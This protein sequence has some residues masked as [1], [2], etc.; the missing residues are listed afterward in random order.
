MYQ[1]RSR[2]PAYRSSLPRQATGGQKQLP[3]RGALVV[4]ICLAVLGVLL[5]L[6]TIVVH[7]G[8][9]QGAKTTSS[10][11]AGRSPQATAGAPAGFNKQ[12]YSVDQATS[13]WVVVNKKRALNPLTY[14]PANLVVPNIPLR[15]NSTGDEKYVSGVMAPALETLVNAA[16]QQSVHLNLQSGYRSY[17]LQQQLFNGYV[18]QQ[19]QEAAEQSSAHPG[20]SEHQTGLAADLGGVSQPACNVAACFATT[21]EGMWLAANA[22]KY[23][24]I[25]RYP[26][27]KTAVTGYE[28]EPWHIRYVGTA[29]STEMH[30]EGV[31]TLEEFFGL[32]AAPTY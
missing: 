28:Y 32:G 7:R 26:A 21:P 24:F 4:I 13:L 8:H 3:W 14:K 15:S 2:R 22:Y 20:H 25:L 11:A 23:G 27:D 12:Q 1:D 10:R 30:S 31:E 16:A 6:G 5:W 29:L 17:A 9:N 19:G 18:Q